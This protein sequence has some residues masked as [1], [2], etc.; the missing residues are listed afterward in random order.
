M[1]EKSKKR[2]TTTTVTVTTTHTEREFYKIHHG[3]EV[4]EKV[5]LKD[6]DGLHPDN[7]PRLT[8]KPL[9]MFYGEGAS[10]NEPDNGRD[11]E[12]LSLFDFSG[13]SQAVEAENPI[14]AYVVRQGTIK[15]TEYEPVEPPRFAEYLAYLLPKTHRESLLGDLVETYPKLKAKQGKWRAGFW[16]YAQVGMSMGSLWGQIIIRL[17]G[18]AWVSDMIRR[19]TR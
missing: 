11:A 13:D 2:S 19:F 7:V 16:A 6:T 15:L 17:I 1:K 4:G 5:R 10:L 14:A 3:F 8:I 12:Q 9:A 18:I